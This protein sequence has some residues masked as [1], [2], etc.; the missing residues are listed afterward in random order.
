L[1]NFGGHRSRISCEEPTMVRQG[2]CESPAASPYETH[3]QEVI[4]ADDVSKARAEAQFRKA[5]QAKDGKAAMAEYEARAAAVRANTER[6]RALRLARDAAAAKTA[7]TAA[8]ATRS[9]PARRKVATPSAKLS[10]W[11]DTQQASG[12]KT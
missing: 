10:D 4:L 5:Q 12:R 7:P 8:P 2:D 3:T 6:L 1:I 11:L 9:K